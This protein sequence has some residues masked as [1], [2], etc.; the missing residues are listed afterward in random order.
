VC[1]CHAAAAAA[2]AAVPPAGEAIKAL[3]NEEFGDGIMSA[4]GFYATVDKMTGNEGEARVVI[5][6]NGEQAA[7]QVTQVQ[8]LS[9]CSV[10][11]LHRHNVRVAASFFCIV[12][13]V[14]TSSSGLLYPAS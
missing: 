8:Q 14:A 4:I 9:S 13:H 1:C 5:T 10:Q 7:Q 2:A 6:F 11:R 3:I 12:A